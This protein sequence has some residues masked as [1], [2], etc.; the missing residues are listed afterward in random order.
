VKNPLKITFVNFELEIIYNLLYKFH[1]CLIY[2]GL[3]IC[4]YPSTFS[5]NWN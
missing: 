4:F 1:Y 2:F 5:E 3:Y